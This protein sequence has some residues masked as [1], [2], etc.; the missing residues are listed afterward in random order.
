[1]D[2][3]KKRNWKFF[4]FEPAKDLTPFHSHRLVEVLAKVN[5]LNSVCREIIIIFSGF[6]VFEGKVIKILEREKSE[7]SDIS[8][9]NLRFDPN[10]NLCVVQPNGVV[11]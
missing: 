9:K 5:R 4:W 6:F 1:M 2:F 8:A 11:L 3:L 7:G 10:S